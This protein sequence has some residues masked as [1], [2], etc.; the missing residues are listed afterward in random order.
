MARL[1]NDGTVSEGAM[2]QF[3]IPSSALKRGRRAGPRFDPAA[4]EDALVELVGNKDAVICEPKHVAGWYA[5]V[6]LFDCDLF[7]LGQWA[8]RLAAFLRDQGV[9]RET[10]MVVEFGRQWSVKVYPEG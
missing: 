1:S 9:P 5:E 10:I 8:E 6:L 7:E 3:M 2:L 4:L